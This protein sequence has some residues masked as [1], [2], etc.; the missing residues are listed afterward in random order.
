MKKQYVTRVAEDAML[1]EKVIISGGKLGM[2]IE[3]NPED[4]LR[5]CGGEYAD[6]LQN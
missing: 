3:L 2:Q 4:L 1:Q 6:L 5:A